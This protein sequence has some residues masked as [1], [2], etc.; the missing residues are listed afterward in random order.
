MSGVLSKGAVVA[1]GA[2]AGGNPPIAVSSSPVSDF[3]RQV[4][5]S[6]VDKG[7]LGL[8]ALGVG[9]RINVRLERFRARRALEGEFLRER[10]RRL[11]E[12]YVA[13]LEVEATGRAYVG[14]EMERIEANKSRVV[15]WPQTPEV[16][17]AG[18]KFGRASEALIRRAA[19][20]RPWTGDRLFRLCT[21]YGL[22]VDNSVI[23]QTIP[24]SHNIDRIEQLEQRTAQL[25]A[26]IM[27][28]VREG[29]PPAAIAESRERA[30]AGS[31]VLTPAARQ[32]RLNAS[33]R[34]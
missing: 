11:D 10:T 17:G 1:S 4:L 2:R 29:A 33:Q 3:W 30:P 32:K 18:T 7:L 19:H 21:E 12:L 16:V 14:L 27:A 22:V 8:A 25:Q 15:K 5:L 23:E 28:A 24:G 9:Y 26:E 20:Y 31:L 13:M 34:S 6:V